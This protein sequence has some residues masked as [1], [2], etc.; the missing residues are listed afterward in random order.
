MESTTQC[1]DFTDT[2]G[3]LRKPDERDQYALEFCKNNVSPVDEVEC[4]WAISYDMRRTLL[5]DGMTV[6]EN[7]QT[8][9]FLKQP[10]GFILLL[11]DFE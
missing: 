11:N 8:F 1:I 6:D 3:K 9:A 4:N 2:T 10:Q 7:L 5:K